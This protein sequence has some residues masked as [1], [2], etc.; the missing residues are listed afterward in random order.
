MRWMTIGDPVIGFRDAV[1][2]EDV[3]ELLKQPA[4]E[5]LL[6][7][8]LVG[9]LHRAYWRHAALAGVLSLEVLSGLWVVIREDVEFLSRIPGE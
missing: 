4:A 6:L 3:W 9:V 5:L 2:C 1:R 8:L 7:L